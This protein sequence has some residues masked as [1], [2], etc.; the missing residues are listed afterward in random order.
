MVF[1]NDRRKKL[2][3]LNA[4]IQQLIQEDDYLEADEESAAD[5][6]MAAKKTVK[7]CQ[8]KIKE[9]QPQ[10]PSITAAPSSGSLITKLPKLNHS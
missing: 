4:H 7:W 2:T 6:F 9:L 1:I 10:S 8:G 3:E 5:V